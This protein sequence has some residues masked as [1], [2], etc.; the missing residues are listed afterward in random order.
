MHTCQFPDV[1]FVFV[2]EQSDTADENVSKGFQKHLDTACW[3][4][5]ALMEKLISA[6]AEI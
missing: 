5:H 3:N 2:P 6:V 4:S 1:P